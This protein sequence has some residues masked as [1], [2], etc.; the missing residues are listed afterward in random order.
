MIF[1]IKFLCRCIRTFKTYVLTSEYKVLP[2]ITLTCILY[3]LYS[4]V[5]D[6][7]NYS[8][9][10]LTYIGIKLSRFYFEYTDNLT[11]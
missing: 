3:T 9:Y 10:I 7:N 11:D 1:I 2:Y 5:H 8:M 4:Y 6:K